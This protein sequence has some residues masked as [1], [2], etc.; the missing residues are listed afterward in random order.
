VIYSVVGLVL[1]VLLLLFAG[2]V[3]FRL[4]ASRQALLVYRAEHPYAEK[5]LD[6]V[7]ARSVTASRRSSDARKLGF[8]GWRAGSCGKV[9][10]VDEPVQYWGSPDPVCGQIPGRRA[11]GF[12]C[13]L[14]ECLVR[15]MT[16]VVDYVLVQDAPQMDL[17]D[18]Q[19]VVKELSAEGAHDPF[20]DRVGSRRLG[21]GLDDLDLFGLEDCVEGGA[22]LGVAVSEEEM[23]GLHSMT[24]AHG[25]IPG[26]LGR[27]GAGRV[28]RYP[29]EVQRAGVVLD[30][31]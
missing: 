18:D 14:V 21:R 20:T 17:V 7:K 31:D 5:D 12:G 9:V 4:Q 1:L 30:E 26:L 3:I 10:L 27:P 2:V 23:Q 15:P 25:Q 28:R 16:V 8:L 22:E 29:G 24:E 6:S 19:H 11:R 13:A